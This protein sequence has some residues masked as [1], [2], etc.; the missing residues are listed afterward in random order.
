M[1]TVNGSQ[2]LDRVRAQARQNIE[3]DAWVNVKTLPELLAED[4]DQPRK[5]V[6]SDGSAA[7]GGTAQDG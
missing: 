2:A 6:T 7:N 4:P 3:A 5:E 1:T